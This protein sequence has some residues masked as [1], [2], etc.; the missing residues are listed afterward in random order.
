LNQDSTESW[1][2]WTDR[3]PVAIHGESA[4]WLGDHCD[5]SRKVQGN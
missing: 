3:F 2:D 4:M 1:T 5:V